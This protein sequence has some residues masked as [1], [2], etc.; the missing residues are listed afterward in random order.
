M[1]PRVEQAVQHVLKKKSFKNMLALGREAVDARKAYEQ[2]EEHERDKV[3]ERED[4]RRIGT[5][6]LFGMAVVFSFVLVVGGLLDLQ[7]WL[8]WGKDQIEDCVKLEDIR[9]GKPDYKGRLPLLLTYTT[10]TGVRVVDEWVGGVQA[11]EKNQD[12]I[13]YNF[14]SRP[15]VTIWYEPG[16]ESRHVTLSQMRAPYTV[17]GGLG[18]ISLLAGFLLWCGVWRLLRDSR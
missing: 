9:W 17:P 10:K 1:T 5:L 13:L 18:Q 15:C 4:L 8:R 3:R 2:S 14:Q 11:R 6:L 7:Q 12:R 16:G